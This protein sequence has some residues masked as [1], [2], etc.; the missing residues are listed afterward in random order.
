MLST[1]TVSSTCDKVRYS[2][3]MLKTHSSGL[4]LITDMKCTPS[5]PSA[6]FQPNF[7]R[8]R[9]E[10]D[11]RIVWE[12]LNI[13]SVSALAIP[14]LPRGYVKMTEEELQ[15]KM[16][17]AKRMADI[18]YDRWMHSESD[19]WKVARIDHEIWISSI[20]QYNALKSNYQRWRVNKTGHKRETND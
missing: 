7:S 14:I 18:A 6:L 20:R 12:S 1:V 15:E 5:K 19:H 8:L 4:Y 11:L 13:L 10:F 9:L 17:I 16:N 3:L 2:T